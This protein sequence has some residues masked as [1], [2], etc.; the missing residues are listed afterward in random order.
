MIIIKP[1]ADTDFYV[2]WSTVCDTPT[3]WGTRTEVAEFL[4]TEGS[5]HDRAHCDEM[6]DRADETGCNARD[7]RAGSWEV[8]EFCYENRGILPR[9]RIIDACA[10]L[11]ADDE[12]GVWD[13]L[14]PF[15]DGVEVLRD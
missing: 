11:A 8:T 7:R 1:A 6:L 5:E 12:P 2:G 4:R 13:L 15:E 10:R 14:E 3:W 9:A